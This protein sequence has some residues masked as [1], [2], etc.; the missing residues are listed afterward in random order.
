MQQDNERLSVM[1]TRVQLF[2]E[3]VHERLCSTTVSDQLAVDVQEV[4]ALPVL[5]VYLDR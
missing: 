2:V 5:W 3:K 4:E 1:K